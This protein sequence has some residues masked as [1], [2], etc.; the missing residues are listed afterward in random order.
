MTDNRPTPEQQLARAIDQIDDP[1]DRHRA[2]QALDE[3]VAQRDKARDKY[4]STERALRHQG[5]KVSQ[6]S[7]EVMQ[8]KERWEMAEYRLA[9]TLDRL[10]AAQAQIRSLAELVDAARKVVERGDALVEADAGRER[11]Q[12]KAQYRRARAQMSAFV[13]EW[14]PD[15]E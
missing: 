2:R 6:L 7:V 4:E 1:A 9:D 5:H 14:Q 11:E 10:E 8:T 3:L 12:A 15:D 13:K